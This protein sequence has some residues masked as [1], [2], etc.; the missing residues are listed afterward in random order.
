MAASMP[1]SDEPATPASD[2][3]ARYEIRVA[4]VLDDCWT[5]WFEGLQVSA[6]DAETVISGVL[7]DQCALHG[8]LVKVRDLGLTLISVR[9]LGPARPGSVHQ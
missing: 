7:I 5:S 9:R 2:G 6:E 1:A 3:P 8:V 4:S